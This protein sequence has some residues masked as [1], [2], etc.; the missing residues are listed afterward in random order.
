MLQICYFRNQN[1]L[2]KCH[3]NYKLQKTVSIDFFV[4]SRNGDGR[5]M[6][7]TRRMSD[8]PQG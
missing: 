3:G 1:I 8:L 2:E 7:P 6:Q 5:I 4:T